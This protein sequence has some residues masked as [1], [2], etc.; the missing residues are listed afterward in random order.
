MKVLQSAAI[1]ILT[2]G[3]MKSRKEKGV[4]LNPHQNLKTCDLM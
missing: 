4:G 2:L 3:D 1:G